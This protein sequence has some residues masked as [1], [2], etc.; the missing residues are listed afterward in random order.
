MS[1][2]AKPVKTS[3]TH[4]IILWI[5]GI[6]AFIAGVLVATVHGT[7][8]RG[9]GLGTILIVLGIVILLIGFLRYFYK[10]Q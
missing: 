4:A 9:S 6:I 2:N 1:E 10:K 5:I 7:H 3:N 8:L